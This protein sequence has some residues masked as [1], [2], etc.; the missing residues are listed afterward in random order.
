M[1]GKDVKTSKQIFSNFLLKTPI[2]VRADFSKIQKDISSKNRYSGGSSNKQYLRPLANKEGSLE[3]LREERF[4]VN[5]KKETPRV[6]DADI[7]QLIRLYPPSFAE[8]KK[9]LE[10][11]QRGEK[12]Y[13]KKAL[14]RILKNIEQIDSQNKIE[15]EKILFDMLV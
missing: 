2:S 8:N 12:Q 9:K 5:F 4:N 3:Q 1:I 15:N 11:E 6:Q 7:K 14:E 13:Q 10:L